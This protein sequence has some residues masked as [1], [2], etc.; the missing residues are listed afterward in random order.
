M[1]W[2][3]LSVS[4]GPGYCLFRVTVLGDTESI[5]GFKWPD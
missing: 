5:S 3:W 4:E 2:L 1:E